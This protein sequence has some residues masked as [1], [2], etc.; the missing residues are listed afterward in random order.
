MPN[1][2]SR[3]EIH[4][5]AKDLGLPSSAD[6]A[7]AIRESC[8]GRLRALARQSACKTP[9]DLL[10]VAQNS[11]RTVF[12]E[13]RSDEDLINLRSEYISRNE[14]GFAQIVEELSAPDVFAITLKLRAPRAVKGA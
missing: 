10:A 12:R 9:S 14:L 7:S 1:L 5:L 2:K 11:L 6:P 3:P 8:R 4:R 13:T